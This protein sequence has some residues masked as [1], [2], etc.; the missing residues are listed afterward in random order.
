MSFECTEV[1]YFELSCD[2]TYNRFD[3]F[4][5]QLNLASE[6]GDPGPLAHTNSISWVVNKVTKL[7]CE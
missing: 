3:Q 5:S 6:E 4:L 2:E 1:S 7:L